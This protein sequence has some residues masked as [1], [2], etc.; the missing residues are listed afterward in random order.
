[1]MHK[2]SLIQIMTKYLLISL[3]AFISSQIVSGIARFGIDCTEWTLLAIDCTVNIFCLYVIF[4]INDKWY[5]KCCKR[6]NKCI[7]IKFENMARKRINKTASMH[8]ALLYE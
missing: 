3:T 1:M 4:K 8:V 6:C 2:K 7:A 5:N